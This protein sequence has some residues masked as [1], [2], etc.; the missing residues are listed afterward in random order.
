[1]HRP[2]I[3][4]KR[5]EVVADKTN[6]T[7]TVVIEFGNVVGRLV[8][9]SRPSGFELSQPHLVF[10]TVRYWKDSRIAWAG[11]GEVPASLDDLVHALRQRLLA[12]GV[13]FLNIGRQN[14][15]LV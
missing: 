1:M 12:C 5:A 3:V 6:G 7:G 14:N 13:S 2:P 9:G 11:A 8:S 4:V 10:D 15:Y